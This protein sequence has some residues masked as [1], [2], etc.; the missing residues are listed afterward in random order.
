MHDVLAR[1]SDHTAVLQRFLTTLSQPDA[2][3]LRGLVR[4]RQDPDS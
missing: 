3:A 1:G 2:A 4:W